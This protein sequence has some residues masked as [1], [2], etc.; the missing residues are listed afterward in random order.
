MLLARVAVTRLTA[1]LFMAKTPPPEPPL[2]VK[3]PVHRCFLL[4][5]EAEPPTTAT[6]PPW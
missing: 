3:L 4:E 1:A 6:P 5:L 2:A